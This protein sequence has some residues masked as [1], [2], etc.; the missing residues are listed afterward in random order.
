MGLLI[1]LFDAGICGRMLYWIKDF[2]NNRT[3]HVKIEGGGLFEGL[4]GFS[5]QSSII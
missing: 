1:K 3:I 2:L 4:P 5:H